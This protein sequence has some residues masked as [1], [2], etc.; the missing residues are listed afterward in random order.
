M[1]PLFL[2]L[3]GKPVV[4]IGGG[5]VGRR[6]AAT[7][8]EAGAVVRIVDPLPRPADLAESMGWIA[9]AY[10]SEHLDGAV[11]VFAAATPD[12]NQRVAAEARERGVW[13][14]SAS[15][16]EGSDFFV[17][18]TVR[19]GGLTIAIGTEGSAPALARR[20]REKLEAEFDAAFADWVALLEEMRPRVMQALA[21]PQRRREL[22]EELSDWPWLEQIRSQGIDATRSA[23]LARLPSS[24]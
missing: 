16:P 15:E 5:R 7:V 10:R 18:S 22:F 3:A 14:N 20:I 12:V 17:P 19:R 24:L 13:V 23:M 11:L 4:V 6:K 1:F 9:E 8:C 21:D 2:D